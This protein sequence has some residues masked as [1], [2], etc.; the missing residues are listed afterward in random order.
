MSNKKKILIVVDWFTPGY[1]AGGPIQS[2]KN[3]AFALKEEYDIYVLT[4][5][6]DHGDKEPYD[7]VEPNKWIIN[8]DPLIN[9]YYAKKSTLSFK[10]LAKEIDSVE[11]DYI[12]LNHLF[13]PYFVLLPLW[14]RYTGKIQGKVVVCPRGALYD[15]ALSVKRYKKDPFLLLFKWMGL[16]KKLSFHATNVR[17]KEAIEKY[18]PGSRI[19]IANNLPKIDQLEYISCD[20]IT[21]TVKCIFIARIVPI[22]NLLFL[23]DI[24]EKVKAMVE[25]TIIGPIED[26]AYWEECK[27]KITQLPTNISVENIGTKQN[28]QLIAILQEHHLFILPTT[29]ENFGHSIFEAMLSGRPVLIS[30]QTPWLQLKKAKAGWDLPLNNSNEFI[31]VI[32][33]SAAW[34]QQQ[35]DEY[36][37]AAWEYAHQFIINPNLIEGYHK[38]FA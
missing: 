38:L 25:L 7:N 32:E 23:L 12:Y 29:G 18:F 27:K 4:T 37:E 22:K 1:K 19:L 5:D 20:K 14:L 36:G 17:E 3:I 16:H 28:D 10:Q 8:L 26:H 9:V 31:K 15:S 13:S 35:F 24:L 2:C 6:T 11:A 34:N 33:Q 21:G 30:D